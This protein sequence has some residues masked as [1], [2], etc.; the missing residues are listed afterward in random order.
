MVDAPILG[1]IS[2]AYLCHVFIRPA[3]A[4]GI[5]NVFGTGTRGLFPSF[6]SSRSFG[7]AGAVMLEEGACLP[8]GPRFG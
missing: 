6:R 3:G 4:L 8:G 5:R 1:W 2:F 7:I